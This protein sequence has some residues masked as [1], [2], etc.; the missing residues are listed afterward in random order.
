MPIPS[1]GQQFGTHNGTADC[2]EISWD[3]YHGEG[4]SFFSLPN[5]VSRVGNE[6]LE[7]IP[8]TRQYSIHRF[9]YPDHL[10]VRTPR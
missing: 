1:E 10:Q 8:P 9:V 6:I 3:S 4:E 2:I 5:L 7:T